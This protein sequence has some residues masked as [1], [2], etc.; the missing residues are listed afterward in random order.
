LALRDHIR[1]ETNEPL[2][3]QLANHLDVL[4]TRI[5][6]TMA[7]SFE[8]IQCQLQWLR[9]VFPYGSA[10]DNREIQLLT[11]MET[12]LKLLQCQSET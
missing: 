5:C 1:A 12:G 11:Q 9:E 8:G 6:H 7:T 2:T 10:N 3:T 4:E